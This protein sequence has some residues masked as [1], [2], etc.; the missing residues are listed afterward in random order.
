MN[1]TGC[2]RISA[3]MTRHLYVLMHVIHLRV[4][5]NV[6]HY[7]VP[8]VV[9]RCLCFHECNPTWP[10]MNL[11]VDMTCYLRASVDTTHLCVFPWI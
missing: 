9:A 8:R 1:V 7:F 2:S 5:M 11:L 10:V 3:I 6:T 4:S